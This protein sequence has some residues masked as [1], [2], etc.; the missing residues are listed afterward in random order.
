MVV[1][2]ERTRSPIVDQARRSIES[3]GGRMLG[4]VLNK[5][6]FHIPRFLYQWL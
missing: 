1:E 5:R 4:V 3:N 6:R 2:A